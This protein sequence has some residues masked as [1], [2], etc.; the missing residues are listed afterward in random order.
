MAASAGG[1]NGALL[2]VSGLAK[3]FGGVQA[4][5]DYDL[6]LPRHMLL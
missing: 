4:L 5:S 6:T 3:Q 1:E 2:E